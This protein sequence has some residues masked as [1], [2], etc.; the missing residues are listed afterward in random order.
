MESNSKR[1]RDEIEQ[2]LIECTKN[3]LLS[4]EEIDELSTFAAELEYHLSLGLDITCEH[5]ETLC[6]LYTKYTRNIF[7]VTSR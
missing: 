2:S 1:S 4:Q 3:C 6:R 5:K 7:F